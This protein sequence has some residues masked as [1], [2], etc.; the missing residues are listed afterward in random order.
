M[1]GEGRV[2]PRRRQVFRWRTTTAGITFFRSSGFPFLTVA[3]TMSPTPM[4][5]VSVCKKA[6][7]SRRS[8]ARK[9]MIE[10]SGMME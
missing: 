7:N 1:S 10:G 5:L 9:D 4:K 8:E 2:V 3:I 6:R